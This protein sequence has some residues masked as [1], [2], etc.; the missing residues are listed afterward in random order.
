M[1]VIDFEIIDNEN[2]VTKP[3]IKP[4]ITKMH[5]YNSIDVFSPSENA[6]LTSRISNIF[7]KTNDFNDSGLLKSN[8]ASTFHDN[9]T[10]TNASFPKVKNYP[11][12]ENVS[13]KVHFIGSR[14]SSMDSTYSKLNCR[15]TSSVDKFRT[16]MDSLMT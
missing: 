14:M 9:S 7:E 6:F 5:K 2:I 12:K 3:V 16:T 4:K 11:N 1:K 10:T 13:N 15:R 8:L